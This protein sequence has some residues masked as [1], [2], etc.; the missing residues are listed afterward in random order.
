M[1]LRDLIFSATE[2]GLFF[3][4]QKKFARCVENI[5]RLQNA[6]LLYLENQ[7]K[8]GIKMHGLTSNPENVEVELLWTW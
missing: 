7:D 5:K 4:F 3:S 8:L 1:K 6:I 2:D